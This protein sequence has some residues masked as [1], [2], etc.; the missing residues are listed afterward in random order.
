[1]MFKRKKVDQLQQEEE[2]VKSPG[3]PLLLSI[4][5]CDPSTYDIVDDENRFQ[6]S[7]DV[8]GIEPSDLEVKV[9]GSR[10]NVIQVV[11]V[12]RQQQELLPE[13]KSED[14]DDKDNGGCNHS[15]MMMRRRKSKKRIVQLIEMDPLGTDTH[16]VDLSRLNVTLTSSSNGSGDDAGGSSSNA[17]LLTLSA[18]KRLKK[19]KKG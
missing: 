14:D 2:E 16:T 12:L 4:K 1:M 13:E 7:L 9:V 11:G 10:R 18:P 15:P 8:Q 3:S 5:H 19:N 17:L 6:I